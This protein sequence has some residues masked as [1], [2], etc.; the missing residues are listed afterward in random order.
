MPKILIDM[1]KIVFFLSLMGASFLMNAQ[2]IDDIHDFITTPGYDL[3]KA[4]AMIDKYQANPKNVSKS[5]GWYYKARI[6]NDISKKDSL[7]AQCPDC[8]MQAFEALKQYQL[9]DS[10]AVLLVLEQN[11]TFFD[12]Y[13][14]Y[15]DL[16]ATDFNKS[17]Y[18]GAFTNFKNAATVEDYIRSKDIEA[19]NG[20]KF[21]ALDTSLIQNTGLAAKLAKDSADAVLY[22][23]R[24][25]DANVAG[26]Q[27]LGVYEFVAEYY[28][29]TNDADAFNAALEKGKKMYPDEQYWTALELDKLSSGGSKTEMF[30]KYD[31]LLKK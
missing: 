28:S 4:K 21:P 6:Y 15:F 24:L 1:K 25:T 16:G 31:E 10:K 8:K 11:I 27:Y 13:G 7:K 9:M 2:N 29:N 14:T 30:K 5:D 3:L 26:P 19:S 20:F 12:I 17:D 22:Y 18:N 23:K